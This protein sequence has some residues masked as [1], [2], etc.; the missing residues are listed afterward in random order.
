MQ[1][2]PEIKKAA[3]NVAGGLLDLSVRWPLFKAYL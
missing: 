3:A 2:L 1:S